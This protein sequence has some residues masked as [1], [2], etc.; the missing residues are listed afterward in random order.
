MQMFV[1]YQIV[2]RDKIGIYSF[3]ESRDIKNQ[4]VSELIIYT[5]IKLSGSKSILL[6]DLD[7]RPLY[8]FFKPN[9]KTKKLTGLFKIIESRVGQGYLTL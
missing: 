5:D 4:T 1:E 2:N 6:D 9:E 3:V 8:M 7:F